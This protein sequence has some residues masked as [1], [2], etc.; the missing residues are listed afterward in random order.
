[1]PDERKTIS[2][3]EA[4]DRFDS[5]AAAAKYSAAHQSLA[6]HGREERCITGVLAGLPGGASVLDL[7]CGTGRLL[8]LLVGLGFEVTAADSSSH[9]I[10]QA[11]LYAGAMD[12]GLGDDAFRVASVFETGF[13]DGAFDAVV[14]NRL[15]HHFPLA[16][17]RRDALR[18]LGRIC[19]GPIVVSFFRN[20]GTDALAFHMKNL[21]RR[22]KSTDRIPVNYATFKKDIVSAGLVA[23]RALATRPLFSRQWYVVVERGPAFGKVRTPVSGQARG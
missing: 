7:P 15:F 18:E 4:I 8:P 5:E 3:Q 19:R 10:D 9:M 17:A 23:V 14:C 11:R 1:M 21:L 6:M 12:L 22:R 20:L 16:Q 13:A 2:P